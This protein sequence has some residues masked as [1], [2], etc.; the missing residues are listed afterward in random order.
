[1]CLMIL[2]SVH[3]GLSIV[4]YINVRYMLMVLVDLGFF[5]DTVDSDRNISNVI[6]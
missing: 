6:S 4:C 1:M 5:L 3:L 2:T